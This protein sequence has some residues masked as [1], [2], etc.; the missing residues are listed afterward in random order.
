MSSAIRAVDLEEFDLILVD[1]S[2][3]ASER[4]ETINEI[5]NKRPNN[6]L[7]VIHDFELSEYRLATTGFEHRQIFRAF[8][9]QTGVVWNGNSV[10]MTIISELELQIRRYTKRIQPDDA[11]G[12]R[13]VLGMSD[14]L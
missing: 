8:T 10:S 1:D 3:S 5:S 12:W 7:I 2:T 14:M 6:R 11:P 4:A 13:K 9:P